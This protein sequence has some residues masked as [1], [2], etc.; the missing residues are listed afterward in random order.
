V[1]LAAL[2]CATGQI[3]VH[4]SAITVASLAFQTVVFSFLSL[5]VWLPDE[6][7]QSSFIVGSVL[8]LVGIVVVS[9]H[10]LLRLRMASLVKD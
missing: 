10:D 7:L 6:T 5:L 3:R 9:G 1:I 8:V 4:F 2:A